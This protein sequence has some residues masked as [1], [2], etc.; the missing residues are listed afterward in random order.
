MRRSVSAS[1]MR[2]SGSSSCMLKPKATVLEETEEEGEA[3]SV[4]MINNKPLPSYST[5]RFYMLSEIEQ[6]SKHI[7]F[8]CDHEYDTRTAETEESA[9]SDIVDDSPFS[10][11]IILYILWRPG[12]VTSPKAL[13]QGIIQQ[14]INQIK[15]ST[16][17]R[18]IN[19][20]LVVEIIVPKPNTDQSNDDD[21]KEQKQ[22]LYQ[23]RVDVVAEQLARCV[24]QNKLLR[25]ELKGLTVGICDHVRAAPGLETCMDAIMLGT[26]DRR[27]FNKKSNIGLVTRHP[28][29]LIGLGDGETD[30]VQGLLQS[31]TICE[32]NGNGDI[33]TFAKRAHTRWC[34]NNKVLESKEEKPKRKKVLSLR[35]RAL[36]NNN[37]NEWFGDP[38]TLILSVVFVTWIYTQLLSSYE[39]IYQ[40]ICH[41]LKS[42]LFVSSKKDTDEL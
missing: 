1:R 7:L 18:S 24:T 11:D 19:I 32:W 13:T 9:N 33:G 12:M 29:D 23:H 16:E 21:E 6:N 35:R 22:R 36:N 41:Q 37:N 15:N 3:F 34:I 27:S 25:D 17:P 42:L 30:G 14:S 31:I 8:L 20:Y 5:E 40:G 2:R 26:R 38:I 28:D 39:D 4:T 10:S